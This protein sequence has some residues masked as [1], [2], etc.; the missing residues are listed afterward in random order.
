LVSPNE[1]FSCALAEAMASGLASV[2]SD[3]PANSQ[4]V[5]E[6]IHGSLVPAGDIA[7]T[8]AAFVRQASD[9]SATQE[10]GAR[11]RQRVVDHFSTDRVVDQ[12]EALFAEIMR[13]GEDSR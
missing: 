1:G 8:A 10:M 6:S 4:L 7:A 2:V 13:T 5:E 12:Y 9:F 11:A 3:I